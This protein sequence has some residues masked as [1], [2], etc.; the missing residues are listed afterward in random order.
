M[1]EIFVILTFINKSINMCM[2]VP[3]DIYLQNVHFVV[4]IFDG[5]ARDPNQMNYLNQGTLIT[6]KIVLTPSVN[7]LGYNL[8]IISYYLIAV[9]NFCRDFLHFFIFICL[10]QSECEFK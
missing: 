1:F 2:A 4:G 6:Q 7:V 10:H 9:D 8:K 5:G 3:L